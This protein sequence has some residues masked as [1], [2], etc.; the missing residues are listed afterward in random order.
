MIPEAVYSKY[1][2]AMFDIAKEQHKMDEYGTELKAVRDTMQL[3]PELKKFIHHPLVPPQSKKETLYAIFADDVSPVVLQ[4][5]YV[6][7]DRR[8]EAAI[9]AAIDGFIDLARAAQNIEVAKIR[10]VKPLSAEEEKQLV[11]SL[12]KMT[13]KH[14][15]PL[16]YMDPS[17][18]GG[19]IVQIGDRLI[20]GSLKRQLT[21][22][23]HSLLQ[24]D[25]MNEVTDE[26]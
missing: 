22:M 14:I 20:D 17:I 23:Q 1:S 13:G 7:I 6:M 11:A 16:Y 2:Q 10:L 8:R 24:S 26:K 25:V 3:N 15:E 9:I 12:E 21:D 4:F 18:I 5:L 19:M